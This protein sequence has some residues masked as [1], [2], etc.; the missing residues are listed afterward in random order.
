MLIRGDTRGQLSLRGITIGGRKCGETDCHAACQAARNDNPFGHTL[1]FIRI[2]GRHCRPVKFCILIFEQC[3]IVT[4][5]FFCNCF[6]VK[7]GGYLPHL[8]L[9]NLR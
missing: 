5:G 2:T 4:Y 3:F 9:I 7:G 6:A 8:L 1:L